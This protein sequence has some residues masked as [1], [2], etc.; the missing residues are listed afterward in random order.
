MQDKTQV[1][2]VQWVCE[3]QHTQQVHKSKVLG[4]PCS[5][6]LVFIFLLLIGKTRQKAKDKDCIEPRTPPTTSGSIRN[7]FLP[8]HSP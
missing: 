2:F 3:A 5:P 8:D 7:K 4:S 1:N 6:K